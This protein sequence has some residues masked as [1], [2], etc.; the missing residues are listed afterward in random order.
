MRICQM[1]TTTIG[2]IAW[3]RR[4]AKPPWRYLGSGSPS[5][6]LRLIAG[7]GRIHQPAL[8]NRSDSCPGHT[9][10]MGSFLGQYGIRSHGERPFRDHRNLKPSHLSLQASWRTYA[11]YAI[12][13][14]QH[15][16][17]H[18]SFSIVAI[19]ARDRAHD[20]QPCTH[21][22]CHVHGMSSLHS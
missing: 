20:K 16:S 10:V 8:S 3:S 1:P 15:L 12:P 9:D 11:L 5:A 6:F 2:E 22:S 18:L 14:K 7:E 17:I 4:S 21:E 13:V 19:A